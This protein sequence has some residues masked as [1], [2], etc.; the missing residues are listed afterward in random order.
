LDF[1]LSQPGL[2][3]CV[4]ETD[5]GCAVIKKAGDT[6]FAE[7][8]N[9]EISGRWHHHRAQR[10]FDV[11]DFFDAHRNELC[12]V[13]SLGDFLKR[14]GIDRRVHGPSLNYVLDTAL[15]EIRHHAA[16]RPHRLLVRRL[17]REGWLA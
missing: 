15:A 16:T 11:F 7:P 3:A 9:T 17:E 10:G 6:G 13:L 2:E 12:N 1:T 8:R 5:D 14:E 4:V